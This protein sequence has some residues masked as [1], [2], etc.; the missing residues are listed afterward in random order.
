MKTQVLFIHGG[1]EGAYEADGKLAASLQQALGNG[2]Q[3]IYPQMPNED[4]PEYAAW[5]ATIQAVLTEKA[6]L[7]GHSLGGSLVLK[8]LTEEKPDVLGVFVIATPYWGAEDWEVEEYALPE[9]FAL[10]Q[11]IPFFFYHSQDDEWVPFD[12]LA[13][14][15]AKFPQAT[16]HEFE[17]RG[18]QFSDDLSEVAADITNL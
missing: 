4:A 18:H 1:G 14:Y 3:V 10:P 7:V 5:K 8:Y 9:D 16:F 15:R 6:V 17:G 2:Y 12:H 13:L 11:N